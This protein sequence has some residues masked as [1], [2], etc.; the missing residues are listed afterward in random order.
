M[1]PAENYLTEA[2]AY[3][4]ESNEAA[5]R[6]FVAAA[7]SAAVP[8]IDVESFTSFKIQTQESFA[9]A[10]GE[11]GAAR[12]D[13]IVICRRAA[14]DP[15][16]V[17][18]EHKWDS[19]ADTEQL[20]S[21][22]KL[23]GKNNNGSSALVFIGSTMAQSNKARHYCDRAMLWEEVYTL[24]EW[25][26]E[27]SADVA[28]F[29]AFIDSQGLS[30]LT[31]LSLAKI[32]AHS[33]SLRVP[34]DCLRIV[35]KLEDEAEYS[36][37]A[38][39]LFCRTTRHLYKNRP[40]RWG[41]VGLEFFR[42]QWNPQIFVGFLHDPRDH[43]LKFVDEARGI[44]LLLLIECM[45]PSTRPKGSAWEERVKAIRNR[46]PGVVALDYTELLS[47]WRKLTVQECLADVIKGHHDE[48]AQAK[49]IYNRLQSWAAVLFENGT[50]E[51]AM[52]ETWP[53]NSDGPDVLAL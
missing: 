33:F 13:M 46:F 36:W 29:L 32:A 27:A 10:E 5:C 21:Y 7:V 24:L 25:F 6:A 40:I 45:P 8:S 3:I 18:S 22:S 1:T 30:P 20:R 19:G 34:D 47:R 44:D 50:L 26:K 17:Y 12:P 2:F 52:R 53:E 49:A 16:T 11:S 42:R 41:R 9:A 37:D 35:K 39:P 48:E 51:Q 14:K 23:G 4:L 43:Q 15:F 31:P 28:N 38:I